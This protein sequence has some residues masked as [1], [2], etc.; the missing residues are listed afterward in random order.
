MSYSRSGD[1]LE[2][3]NGAFGQERKCT[4]IRH[5]LIS[6]SVLTKAIITQ[7]SLQ[8]ELTD[9]L[10]ADLQFHTLNRA[11]P[12]QN[13]RPLLTLWHMPTVLKNLQSTPLI[14]PVWMLSAESFGQAI[15]IGC[16]G[17]R[18]RAA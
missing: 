11:T 10:Q 9:V 14:A 16:L 6:H 12:S 5:L 17:H 4:V 15:W 18:I 3:T 2:Q 1:D 13:L 7:I 8:Q